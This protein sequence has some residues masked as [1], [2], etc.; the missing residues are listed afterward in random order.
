MNTGNDTDYLEWIENTDNLWNDYKSN[1][2]YIFSFS[3]MRSD[4]KSD[5][6]RV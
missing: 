5:L 1:D 4:R 6:F 3:L 2:N